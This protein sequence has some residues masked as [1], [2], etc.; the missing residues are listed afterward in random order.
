[1]WPRRPG[2]AEP[3]LGAV[4]SHLRTGRGEQQAS[5]CSAPQTR[6]VAAVTSAQ[7]EPKLLTDEQM[8]TFIGAGYLTLTIDELGAEFHNALYEHAQVEFGPKNNGLTGTG[9]STERIPELLT[10]INSPTVVGALTSLIGPDYAHGHL[11]ASGCALHVSTDED[12]IFH[13][14][15]QVGDLARPLSCRLEVALAAGLPAPQS[16]PPDPLHL[17]PLLSARMPL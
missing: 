17:V 1:M 5:E 8:Q 14:D 3:M 11:G 15:T 12:Q 10:M 7:V 6:D 13:K 9:G 16:T 2:P 4:S